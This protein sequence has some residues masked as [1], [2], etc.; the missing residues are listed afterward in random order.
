[1]W[2]PGPSEVVWR[3]NFWFVS[4]TFT[5]SRSDVHLESSSS[6]SFPILCQIH[7]TLRVQRLPPSIDE[8]SRSSSF[9]RSFNQRRAFVQCLQELLSN[10]TT[11][12]SSQDQ[13]KDGLV[14]S[15]EMLLDRF[16]S[17]ALRHQE[18]R[19]ES[20]RFSVSQ[21]DRWIFLCFT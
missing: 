21:N 17:C 12:V 14:C 2:N 18:E 7:F 8:S 19:E 10:L 3:E 6:R 5:R 1:M 20:I 11:K 15:T 13:L 16:A 4:S 9:V